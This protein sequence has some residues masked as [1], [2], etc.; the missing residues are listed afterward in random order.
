M[1]KLFYNKYNI[2]YNIVLPGFLVACFFCACKSDNQ[3]LIR[4]KVDERVAAVR[5]KKNMECR[6]MLLNEAGKIVDS[7]LLEEAMG[8]LA[9]S[10]MRL[11]PFRPGRPP[12]LPA[13]DS[14]P[15]APFFER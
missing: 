1:R 11:K 15:V 13:I 8:G 9:D 14:S 3:K 2:L 7:L 4:E 12:A 10:L 6:E 5:A